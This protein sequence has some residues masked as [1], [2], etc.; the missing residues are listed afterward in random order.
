M[1]KL[2]RHNI[3][4]IIPTCNSKNKNNFE[5]STIIIKEGVVSPYVAFIVN[6]LNKKEKKLLK[7]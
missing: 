4:N 7:K 6:Y 3:N 2:T 5:K 1:N